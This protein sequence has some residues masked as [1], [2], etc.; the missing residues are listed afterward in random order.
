MYNTYGGDGFGLIAFPCNQFGGQ[1][2]GTSQEEREFAW[3][4]FGL[5]GD[6]LPVFDK[7][8]VNGPFAHPV[9]QL[10]RSQQPSSVPAAGT[11]ALRKGEIEWNY[12]KFLVNRQG[13]AVKRFK[14]SFDP[15]DFETDLKLVLAG[16]DPLPDECIMHVS[17]FAEYPSALVLT[18][19]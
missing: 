6:A 14:P 5:S 1:A 16:K 9:Y 2:P 12:T 3:K 15:L 4:K 13:Q 7:V 18:S 17:S 19:H 8:D 10:L 11:R